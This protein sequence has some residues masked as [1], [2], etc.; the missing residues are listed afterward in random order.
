MLSWGE[1]LVVRRHG[2][3]DAVSRLYVVFSTAES[4]YARFAATVEVPAGWSCGLPPSP[5]DTALPRVLS[6]YQT[7]TY[8]T[9]EACADPQ[10]E[11]KW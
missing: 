2:S 9:F 7:T 11:P 10:V 4:G 3:A 6:S 8:H 5:T 1:V